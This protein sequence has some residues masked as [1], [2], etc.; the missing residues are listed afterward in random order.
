[1]ECVQFKA[2]LSIK[3]RDKYK[4]Q[5]FMFYWCLW[6]MNKEVSGPQKVQKE[7]Y[8]KNCKKRK[9]IREQACLKVS[10][11]HPEELKGHPA[12][13]HS[14]SYSSD[15]RRRTCHPLAFGSSLQAPPCLQQTH[16]LAPLLALP[17]AAANPHSAS[18]HR[19]LRLELPP[20]PPQP[21]YL[22][23]CLM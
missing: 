23:L 22:I 8:S 3:A 12:W 14:S 21:C 5:K 19:S 20:L 11:L 1:M 7:D 6:S 16:P 9:A 15:S 17:G 10:S 4:C 13:C 2:V 18:F